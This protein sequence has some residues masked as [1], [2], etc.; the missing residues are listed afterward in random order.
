MVENKTEKLTF[1]FTAT[2]LAAMDLLVANGFYRNRTDFVQQAVHSR[3]EASEDLVDG[4]IAKERTPSL[5]I[6]VQVV[7]RRRLLEAQANHQMLELKTYGMLIVESD[8]EL[9]LMQATVTRVQVYG[10]T[11]APRLIKTAYGL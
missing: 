3:L 4:L 8:V 7:T 5:V 10:I 11:K 1:N 2:D 9:A 6:G